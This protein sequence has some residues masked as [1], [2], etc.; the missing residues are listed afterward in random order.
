[1]IRHAG[2]GDIKPGDV[3]IA[4]FGQYRHRL[5]MAAAIAYR[6]SHARASIRA[7]PTMRAFGA[8]SSTPRKRH[9]GARDLADG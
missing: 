4:D 7:A 2:R 6:C 1:M 9:E 5:A 3:L 8:R